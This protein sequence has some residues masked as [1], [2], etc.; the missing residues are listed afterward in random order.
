MACD[1][2]ALRRYPM[3][4]VV[5]KRALPLG[6]PDVF[7]GSADQ[8]DFDRESVDEVGAAKMR[9]ALARGL[10]T[11]PAAERP[12]LVIAAVAQWTFGETGLRSFLV[13]GDSVFLDE[14]LLV[15]D[16]EGLDAHAALLREGAALFG[17]D[18]G[19]TQVRR[20]ARWSDGRG[21]I[22]DAELDAAL[23]RLS[24][25]FHA[26]P[27]LL[28]EAASRA[29]R[30]P[31]VAAE[32]ESLRAGTH[33]DTTSIRGGA[34]EADRL[35]FLTD[36]LWSCL[37]HYDDP[38]AVL[39]RLAALPPPY[40]RIIVVRIFEAEMLNGSVQQAFFN[41]SGTIMPE[42]VTALHAMGLSKQ[43][44][45]VERGIAMFPTPFPR[46][47]EERRSFMERQGAA[48]DDALERLTG[49]VDD[50][51]LQAAMIATA[52]AADILPK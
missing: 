37:N 16:S 34:S 33:E 26:L 31:D 22:L 25:R 23:R 21:K 42:V 27:R 14:V 36:R 29:V 17:P 7:F 18:F 43:A 4:A 48:L 15:L 45:A 41:S 11:F 5:E 20:Y 12:I 38:P 52:K 47:L 9:A 46:D 51:E 30:S 44:A 50:G 1:L 3:T 6:L 49:D 39:A 2:E 40:A 13:S 19:G 32:Y 8:S 28:D 10:A 24:E 35:R